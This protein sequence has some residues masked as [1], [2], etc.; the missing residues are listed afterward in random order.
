MKVLLGSMEMG[1][2]AMADKDLCYDTMDAF[3]S[4]GHREIDTAYLY[5]GGTSESII[6]S[7]LTTKGLHGDVPVATK[8]NPFFNSRLTRAG[9]L[10]QFSTSLA[11]LEAPSVDLFYLHAPDHN[12]PIE[13]S[14]QTCQQLYEEGKFTR[15]G[16]SNFSAWEVAN[17]YHI[18]KNNNWILPTVYQ[19]MYNPITRMVEGE[20]FPALRYFGISF[21]DYNPLAGGLLSGNY[22]LADFEK[23]LEGRFWSHG[24]GSSMYRNRFWRKSV[25]QGVELVQKALAEVYGPGKT[26]LANTCFRWLHH[27]SLMKPELGDGI[28]IGCSKIEHVRANI[29][30]CKDGPLDSRVVEAFEEAW[31]LDR[32]NCANYYR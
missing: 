13:E 10:E 29:E 28:I 11:R 20:L 22:R 23:E 9:V 5:T 14:L 21:Y 31:K 3:L 18:C 4:T 25:F 26:T 2:G 12:T 7:Y 6:G 32:V 19:G 16:L 8:A 1:R 24:A 30:A 15:F 17:V 27:H